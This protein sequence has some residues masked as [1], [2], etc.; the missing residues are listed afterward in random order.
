MAMV[1]VIAIGFGTMPGV[2]ALG[3]Y[4][5]G[6]LAKF[7]AEAIEHIDENPIQALDSM[8]AS[9]GQV[10]ASAVAPQVMPAFIS[11]NLSILD[12]NI[13]MAT[14]LGIVGAGGI[15]YEL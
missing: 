14:R 6:F 15:G 10:L 13:R 9:K 11:H 8:G 7:Y 5:M 3:F 4:T 1:L 12:R 2:I